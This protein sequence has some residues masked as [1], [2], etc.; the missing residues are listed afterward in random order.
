MG[1]EVIMCMRSAVWRGTILALVLVGPSWARQDPGDGPNAQDVLT[2]GPIHEAYA[3][4]VIFN[5]TLG[6]LVPKGP[7][8]PIEERP[9]DQRPEGAD[10]QWIPGYWAWDDERQ[11]FLWVSGIWRDIPPGRQWV[12][13]YWNE[14]DGGFQWTSGLWAPDDQEEV[15]Y[16]PTPPQSLEVGPNVPAPSESHVWTPGYWTWS[17]E[18]YVWAPGYWVEYQPS[19]VWVPPTYV[20]TPSG[21]IFVP[22]YWDYTLASR[23]LLF[24]PVYFPQNVYTQPN[25]VYTP[26]VTIDSYAMTDNLFC[27]PSYRHYYFGDYYAAAPVGVGVGVAAAAAIVPWYAFQQS[28]TWYDPIYSHTRVVS[29]RNDPTWETRVRETYVYRTEHV[30]ARP[31]RTFQAQQAFVAGRQG[32][33]ARPL[34]LARTLAQVERQENTQIRLQRV[35]QARRAELGQRQQALQQVREQRV[36]LEAQTQARREA[37]REQFVV[38]RQQM[39][40][41]PV[42][43]QARPDR[44]Q[45]ARPFARPR[46]GAD[47][48]TNPLGPGSQPGLR[49]RQ[50]QPRPDLPGQPR[51]ERTRAQAGSRPFPLEPDPTPDRPRT[52]RPRDLPKA[53]RL[54]DLPK[55]ERPRTQPRLD[56]IPPG[57][58][59]PGAQPKRERFRDLPKA[60]RRT[61]QPDPQ[62]SQQPGLNLPGAQPK[63]ERFRDLPKAERPNAQPGPQPFQRPTPDLTPAQPGADRPGLQPRPRPFEPNPDRPKAQP[64][65]ERTKRQPAPGL[66]APGGPGSTGP[67][68][69]ASALPLGQPRPERPN[70]RARIEARSVL[71][72]RPGLGPRQERLRPPF[73]NGAASPAPA[74]QP[75]PVPTAQPRFERPRAQPA[76][77]PVPSIPPGP[78]ARPNRPNAASPGLGQP[79]Q[80]PPPGAERTKA[81]RRQE[82]LKKA[83]ER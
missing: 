57:Q 63:R 44:A 35:D 12:P 60:E 75:Q 78:E 1:S 18:H 29:L 23:G 69:A 72:D 3:E 32:A 83:R 17:Q 19:W 25:F 61:F 40:R 37:A 74:P 59:L 77:R 31:A 34:V 9:P 33:G 38:R 79:A 7:P 51:P 42:A 67:L 36:R 65:P 68:G 66:A 11:D 47:A 43:A 54:R 46:P 76:P 20:A 82:Q 48:P 58:D 15:E 64:R 6:D 50:G 71:T 24:A 26:A 5:P 39:P 10:V 41:S 28:H 62:P 2:R 70:L 13:G 45:D 30:D 52:E 22:G 55:A 73:G 56:A 49:A 81:Q 27:R 16:L 4:P 8:N 21:C 53:E 80:P 14:V